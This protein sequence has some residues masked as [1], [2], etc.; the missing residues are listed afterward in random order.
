[1]T[2]EY[3]GGLHWRRTVYHCVDALAGSPGIPHQ[4]IE[5]HERELIETADL[6]VVSSTTLAEAKRPL[7]RRLDYLPNPAD[8]RHFRRA[9]DPDVSVPAELA[10]VP[11][12][13][14]GFIGAISDYKID[15][16][17]LCRI[18]TRH[19]DWQLV[20]VGP[21]G[22]GEPTTTVERLG[23]LQNVHL[24]GTR[25]YDS[26]PSYLKGFDVC[27][28]PNRLNRYTEHMFPLKFFE[29]LASGKPVVMSPLPALRDFWPLAYVASPADESAFTRRIDDALAEPSDAP[30]RDQRIRE[31]SKHDWEHQ[32]RRLLEFVAD[33]DQER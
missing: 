3:V 23:S 6:T 20:M 14:I 8:F 26:L 22:E 17:S 25:S 28:L 30:I 31:A 9:N 24:L 1:M 27:L 32:A 19:A 33:L 13:R 2:L 5:D 12:P 16:D 11:A 15:V 7:A 10:V 29:Y 18:F 4:V 21:V